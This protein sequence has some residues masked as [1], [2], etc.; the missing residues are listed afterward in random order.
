MSIYCIEV[1]F[2]ILINFRLKRL[3]SQDPRH[4]GF[5]F[6]HQPASFDFPKDYRMFSFGK[7]YSINLGLLK[8]YGGCTCT[9]KKISILCLPSK[10]IKSFTLVYYPV[11]NASPHQ[12]F[13]I[14]CSNF[15]HNFL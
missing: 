5:L 9:W 10:N 8:Y 6:P 7:S 13:F 14:V 1:E 11:L 2:L 3:S 12:H 15:Q 4:M